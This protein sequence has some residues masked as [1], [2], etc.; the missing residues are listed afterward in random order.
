LPHI[1]LIHYA[2][3]REENITRPAFRLPHAH[4]LPSLALNTHFY[5]L[6][7][8]IYADKQQRGKTALAAFLPPLTHLQHT[9]STPLYARQANDYAAETRLCFLSVGLT[10]AVRFL[11]NK[12]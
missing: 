11:L 5:A 9:H 7:K 2:R 6:K 3:T 8:G 10:V 4:L 12:P 1:H